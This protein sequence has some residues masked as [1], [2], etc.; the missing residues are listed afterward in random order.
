MTRS[1]LE[2][3]GVHEYTSEP[4]RIIVDLG[5]LGTYELIRKKSLMCEHCRCLAAYLVSEDEPDMIRCLS[6]LV[7]SQQS[8]SSSNFIKVN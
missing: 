8:I 6:C 2:E 4:E 1:F 7:K 5:D 3:T